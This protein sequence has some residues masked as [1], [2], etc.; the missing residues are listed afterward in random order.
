MEDELIVP[1]DWMNDREMSVEAREALQFILPLSD[2]YPGIE[3]WFR[4]KVV[5]GLYDGSRHLLRV[6][7]DGKLV[8]LGIAKS[9]EEEQKICTVRIAPE[10]AGRG[11][12]V[13]IFD[14]LL[15]WLKTD[16]PHFTVSEHKLT[17]F[18]RI[19]DWYGFELTSK[20]SG[21]YLPARIE[22]GYNELEERSLIA[23]RSNSLLNKK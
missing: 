7:R 10:Y 16:R 19:F 8:G 2:D 13:R 14:G 21:L 9:T 6:E 22:L 5:P 3:R 1:T 17:A 23:P 4:N 11:M 18:E 15:N 20:N 12:G